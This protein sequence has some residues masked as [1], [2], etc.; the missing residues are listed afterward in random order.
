MRQETGT[1]LFVKLTLTLSLELAAVLPAF[2]L[3]NAA[4]PGVPANPD[5][6]AN[7]ADGVEATQPRPRSSRPQKGPL[8]RTGDRPRW[9]PSQRRSRA[10]RRARP[11]LPDEHLIEAMLTAPVQP[12]LK[13]VATWT[14]QELVDRLAAKTI[15]EVVLDLFRS[16]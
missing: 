14:D 13:T 15:P 6:V 5:G 2:K 3:S 4:M 11:F 16:P 9:P 10:T 8:G 12:I 7:P 1:P